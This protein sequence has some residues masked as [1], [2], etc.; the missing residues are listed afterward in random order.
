MLWVEFIIIII[1]FLFL[2]K[3]M[4]LETQLKWLCKR[5]KKKIPISEE[6]QRMPSN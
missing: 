4:E 1:I 6:R 3:S 5:E 2:S